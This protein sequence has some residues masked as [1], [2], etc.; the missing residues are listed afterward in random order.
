VSEPSAPTSHTI[1]SY[2]RGY[3]EEGRLLGFRSACGFVTATW[4]LLCPRC[5]KRD[6][7]EVNLS[8]RGHIA[9]YTV[10]TVPAEEFVNDAPYA[11]VVVEL[12]EG[13]R[14]T[15]WMPGIRAPEEL[16]VG[17]PVAWVTSYRPGVQFERRP[18]TERSAP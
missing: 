15:G 5:G 17:L 13:G 3:E 12:E 10:Q 1:E 16:E 4:G 14:I 18:P 11:Y 7:S 8:G 9:A 6:L 2:R